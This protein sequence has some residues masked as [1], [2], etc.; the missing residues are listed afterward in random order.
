MEINV[1]DL[2]L[3]FIPIADITRGARVWDRH[4][5]IFEFEISSWRMY[6]DR[7]FERGEKE[8]RRIRDKVEI[9]GN[10]GFC[11]LIRNGYV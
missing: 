4:P 7:Y 1:A 5:R 10:H 3:P 6:T 8:T 9:R 11:F 2:R